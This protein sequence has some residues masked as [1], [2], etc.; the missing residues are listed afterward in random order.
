MPDGLK[1]F[2]GSSHPDLAR[3][4]CHELG[5]VL[6][7]AHTTR[8]SNENLKVKIDENVR[9]Q[10]VFVVQTACPPLH[11]N[12]VET[13]ILLDAL[14]HA[15]AKRVTA[16]LPYFPYARSDKKDEPRISITARLMA[17]LLATAGADRVLTVDL[18]SPQIQGFFSMP[19]DQLSG[20]PV[21]C[22]RLKSS[23]LSNTVV[24]AADVGEAK[25]AGRFAKRLD[26]PLAFIDKRRAG[27]DE[28]ARPA[29]VIGDIV[30]KDCL[31]VDDEIATG[32]TLF[33][34][35]EFLLDRGARSVSAAVVHPVMSGRA[36]ERL[37]TSRIARLLVTNT[38]PIPADKVSPKLEIL[39]M[40]PLLATA[41]THIHDGS[42]VSELFS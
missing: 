3:E 34:A 24:V 29:H 11:E 4:I 42:S 16:V 25:D 37:A 12:I 15:S 18:H 20:V 13:L 5:I 33:G 19:A 1:V 31:L 40:A 35:T 23:D 7:R 2:A 32:G 28:K 22:E 39:S 21:L 6:G 26:L 17:D 8:F 36:A 30:G 41:I 14:K 10:D 9:E 27:D 38:I